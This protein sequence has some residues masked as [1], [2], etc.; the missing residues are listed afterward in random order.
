MAGKDG[1]VN[2][3]ASTDY[4]D[5]LYDILCKCY[6]IAVMYLV[7]TVMSGWCSSKPAIVMCYLTRIDDQAN[8]SAKVVTASHPLRMLAS[9]VLT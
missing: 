5:T 1:M 4:G 8:I 9:L 6:D 7:I 3:V 2:A